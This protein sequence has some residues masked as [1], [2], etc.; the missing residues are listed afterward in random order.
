LTWNGLEQLQVDLRELPAM[1]T[2]DGNVLVETEANAAA[3]DI[4]AAYPPGELR[5][6]VKVE[7]E[8]GSAF[9]VGRRVLT[10]SGWAWLYEH[11]SQVR[12]TKLGYN[13]GREPARHVYV[14]RMIRHRSALEDQTRALLQRYGL[15]VTG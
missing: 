3:S 9:F 13:R 4:R 8:H 14:P 15:Q 11:G 12:H 1:L 10:T 7:T 6:G 5:D 2:R